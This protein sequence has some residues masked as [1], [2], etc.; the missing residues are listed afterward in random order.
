MFAKENDGKSSAS[1]D[2]STTFCLEA[3]SDFSSV[4]VDLKNSFIDL[5]GTT[6]YNVFLISHNVLCCTI[7]N[8][9][10]CVV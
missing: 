2:D 6:S 3:C 10:F 4:D 1:S 7:Y 5:Q 9:F 8:V